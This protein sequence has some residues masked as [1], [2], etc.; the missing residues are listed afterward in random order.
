M[1]EITTVKRGIQSRRANLPHALFVAG[2]TLVIS[3]AK[4]AYALWLEITGL[5]FA[6]L[7]I[8]GGSALVR[9]YRADH[10]ADHTRFVTVTAFTLVCGWFTVFSFV[11]ANRPRK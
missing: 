10:L 9:Q 3:F 5:L 11:K 4:T 1:P 6:F 7:T 2:K 8:S